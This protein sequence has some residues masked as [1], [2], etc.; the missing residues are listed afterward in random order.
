MRWCN[1][2]APNNKA[3][4]F[5]EQW[6]SNDERAK[7]IGRRSLVAEM[8]VGPRQRINVTGGTCHALFASIIRDRAWLG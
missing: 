4:K 6:S 5:S 2:L 8:R 1:P 3:F 7:R